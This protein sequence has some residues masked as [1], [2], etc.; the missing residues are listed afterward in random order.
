MI[1]YCEEN[2]IPYRIGTPP[3]SPPYPSYQ[4]Q[5]RRHA[6]LGNKPHPSQSE[7]REYLILDA[8]LSVQEGQMTP[9]EFEQW[10]GEAFQS[11]NH[12]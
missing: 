11:T 12:Q 9:S 3:A 5:V 6:E 7:L 10:T 8:R 1:R 4:S 2:N